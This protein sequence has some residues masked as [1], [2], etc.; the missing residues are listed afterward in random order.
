MTPAIQTVDGRYFDLVNPTPNMVDINHIAEALSKFCR[1]NGHCRGVYSVARHSMLMSSILPPRL[2][3]AGLLHD[4]HEA[5]THD[6]TSPYKAAL[7]QISPEA[8]AGVRELERRATVAIHEKLDVEVS[9]EDAA[10]IK[11]ADMRALATE[12]RHIMHPQQGANGEWVCLDG[13]KPIMGSET[14]VRLGTHFTWEQDCRSFRMR[15]WRLTGNMAA[16]RLP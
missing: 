5:Y 1:F 7:A 2:Q 11:R 6:L 14:K 8:L 13:I 15:S 12:R 4:A 3:L 16:R 10:K 9:T